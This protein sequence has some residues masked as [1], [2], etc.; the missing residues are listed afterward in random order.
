LHA[1]K[2][3]NRIES[4]YKPIIINSDPVLSAPL[5]DLVL[6]KE[7]HS[8]AWSFDGTSVLRVVGTRTPP[9]REH[10]G[11]PG[12]H[13]V[14]VEAW[15]LGLPAKRAGG[16]SATRG[17]AAGRGSTFRWVEAALKM[18]ADGAT[19]AEVRKRYAVS[20]ST[21]RRYRSGRKEFARPAQ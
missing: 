6:L 20:E 2:H 12:A 9:V 10:W 13:A 3:S 5:S 19:Y 8:N 15:R 16:A 4:G 21:L 17:S 1:A 14:E 7:M 18:L 11:H